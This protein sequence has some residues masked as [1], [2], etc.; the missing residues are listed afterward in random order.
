MAWDASDEL[1]SAGRG[2]DS[3]HEDDDADSL[4]SPHTGYATASRGL[5]ADDIA[6]R[7]RSY[8]NRLELLPLEDRMLLE[9]VPTGQRSLRDV[10]RLLTV[11]PGQL[12]RRLRALLRRIDHP[13]VHHLFHKTCPLPPHLRQIGIEY[14]FQ[15]L[16]MRAIADKHQL[17]ER[18]TKALVEQLKGYA[19]AM[20]FRV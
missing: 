8:R 11:S 6:D 4:G 12:S 17:S 9:L 7:L 14:Y 2:T 1:A 10:A 18:E 19:K 13:F 16:T 3:R 15:D 5:R 20:K